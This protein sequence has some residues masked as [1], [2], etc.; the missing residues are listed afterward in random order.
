MSRAETRSGKPLARKRALR[1]D[2][3]SSRKTLLDAA[4]ELFAQK[5]PEGLTVAAVARKAGL[6][7]STAYQHFRNRNEVLRAVSAAFAQEVRELLQE[8]RA[9]GDQIEFFV[10]YFQDRPDI[11]RLWM[12]QLLGEQGGARAPGWGDYV[13]SLER[14]AHSPKSQDGIDAE[15]LGVIGMSSALVWSLM[16]RQRTDSDQEANAETRRFAAE[17]K[18]LFLFGAL[19]P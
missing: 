11:A 9:F 13:S 4:R 1:S 15:M 16:A 2:A 17:L 8:N 7:R 10:H 19:R 5:G 18:R 3:K 12:F 6:N 14:L